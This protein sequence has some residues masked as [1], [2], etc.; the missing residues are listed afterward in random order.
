MVG[1]VPY[2]RRWFASRWPRRSAFMGAFTGPSAHAGARTE[3]ARR[4][5]R[6]RFP[7][8]TSSDSWAS[9]TIG[10]VKTITLVSRCGVQRLCPLS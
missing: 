2:A 9:S 3:M 5:R 4:Y 6:T 7:Q 1:R 8:V 10:T